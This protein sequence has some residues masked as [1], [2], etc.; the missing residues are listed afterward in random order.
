MDTVRSGE[1]QRAEI[2]YCGGRFDFDCRDEGYEARAARDYRA[3]LLGDTGRLLHG[4]GPVCLSERL[5]YAGPFYFET[6]GMLD[7]DIVETERKQIDQCTLAVFLLDDRP[8]PGT[9][10]EMVYAASAQKKICIAYIRDERETE[11]AL[12]SACWYPILLCRSVSREG[13]DL[14]PCDHTAEACG[15]ILDYLRALR[16]F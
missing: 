1:A 13:I 11:S 10:A 3:V 15:K 9:V 4:R 14:I 5:M 7:R 8:C 12:R 16:L 2:V 6:D